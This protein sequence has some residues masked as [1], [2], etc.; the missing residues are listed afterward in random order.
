[1]TAV[2]LSLLAFVTLHFEVTAEDIAI[3]CALVSLIVVAIWVR[4]RSRD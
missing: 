3:A 4:W 2:S 1:M